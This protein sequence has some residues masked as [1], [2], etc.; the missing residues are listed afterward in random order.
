MTAKERRRK[1]LLAWIYAQYDPLHLLAP[2]RFAEALSVEALPH[3]GLPPR[4]V[5]A[6]TEFRHLNTKARVRACAVFLFA[7]GT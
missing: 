2:E 7:R 1:E 6:V 3:E 4:F 5:Q